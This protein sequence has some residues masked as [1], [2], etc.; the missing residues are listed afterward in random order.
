MDAMVIGIDVSKNR[1]DVAVRPT[2][3]SLI[4][5]RTGVGIEDLIAPARIPLGKCC[6]QMEPLFFAPSLVDFE[7]PYTAPALSSCSGSLILP[8]HLWP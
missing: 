7:A 3:E 4:F 5:K 1:L 8:S 6:D 2:G